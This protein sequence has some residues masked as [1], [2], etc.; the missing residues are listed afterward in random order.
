MIS[1]S[2]NFDSG[3]IGDCSVN[4]LKRQLLF[5]ARTD[6][7]PVAMW[8]YFRMDGARAGPFKFVLMNLNQCLGRNNW[9]YARPVYRSPGQPWRRAVDSNVYLDFKKGEFRFSM[10]LPDAPVEVAYCYPYTP[11]MLKPLLKELA[12]NGP[13]HLSYPGRSSEGQRIPYIVLPTLNKKKTSSVIWLLCREHAGEVTGSYTLEGFLRTA[14]KSKLRN[15][16]EFHVI[17]F[18]DIDGVVEGC[19][20]KNS[21]PVDHGNAWCV[22]SSR[23]E[24]KLIMKLMQKSVAKGKRFVLLFNFHSPGPERRNYLYF[25]NPA[26][27][28]SQARKRIENLTYLFCK[29]SPKNFPFTMNQELIKSEIG[30][31]SDDIERKQVTY[32]NQ[33][34]GADPISV[35]TAYHSV[36]SGTVTTPERCR[37]LGASLLKAIEHY[38]LHGSNGKRIDLFSKLPPEMLNNSGWVL[39]QIPYGCKVKFNRKSAAVVPM[40]K[41][42]TSIYFTTPVKYQCSEKRPIIQIN[43]KGKI[44]LEI[45]WYFYDKRGVRLYHRP[46]L[47]QYILSSSEGLQIY[48]PSEFPK[49]AKTA[50]PG[51]RINGLFSKLYVEV[52]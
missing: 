23:P 33:M 18:V 12:V 47:I 48:L 34:Y 49:T 42:E 5:K 16:V 13:L 3:S 11:I 21:P 20:G 7:S 46:N 29:M 24:V 30:W 15:N 4:E 43:Y 37:E 19:Y 40:G 10:V 31:Y 17:S 50:R 1:I 6:G 22:N 44:P 36:E 14:A 25:G 45:L 28:S 38:L 8:F 27:L 52:L 32:V 51:F 41:G 26:L 35:E 39:W 2:T 9:I